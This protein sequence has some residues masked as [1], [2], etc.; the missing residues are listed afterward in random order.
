MN[1]RQRLL[2]GFAV[3]AHRECLHERN[4]PLLLSIALICLIL[5]PGLSLASTEAAT[6]GPKDTAAVAER[7]ARAIE[8]LQQWYTPGTGLYTSTG[9]WNSANAI[10]TL[11]NYSRVS[12]STKYLPVFSN[13]LEAAQK[14][15]DGAP[16][17]LNKYYDDEGWWALAWIDVYDLT[18]EDRYLQTAAAIFKDMQLGWDD[19]TCGG[20]VWW[21]KDNKDKNAIENE[22]FLSVAASLTNR[23]KDPSVRSDD[24]S[25]MRK[26][27]QWFLDSGMINASHLINDGLTPAHSVHCSNNGKRAWTYNQGVILGAMVE[28]NKAQPDP[29]VP[30][31]A[32]AIASAAMDHLKDMHGAMGELDNAHD[33]GDVPQFKGIFVR[34]LM[35]LNSSYPIRNYR[36]FIETNAELIWSNNRNSSDQLGFW[37]GGPFDLADAA[38]QSSALDVLVAAEALEAS[39]KKR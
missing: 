1:I 10:T 20:G 37:W 15:K 7:T 2:S 27:W 22:L 35:Q 9:W 3:Q 16:G 8:V 12:H 39:R 31:L 36:R 18:G 30:R 21:S 14:G 32:K 28:M 33:G 29:A 25:W 24:L 11:A 38:R 13:T 17:F 4:Y 26:E 5:C 34:N 6:A 23:E 19:E